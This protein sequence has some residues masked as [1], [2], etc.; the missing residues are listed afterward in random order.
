M[1]PSQVTL[2]VT[3]DTLAELPLAL[4]PASGA[5]TPAAQAAY[6]TL[7]IVLP[8]TVEMVTVVISSAEALAPLASATQDVA[9]AAWSSF[10]TDWASEA[11]AVVALVVIV[12]WPAALAMAVLLAVPSEEVDVTEVTF[13][14][15][16]AA[17]KGKVLGR[18]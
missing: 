12:T 14:A 11:T 5:V 17:L 3:P 13:W 1:V 10:W 9:A 18:S 2:A 6:A 4:L 8:S 16:P 7:V 15:A